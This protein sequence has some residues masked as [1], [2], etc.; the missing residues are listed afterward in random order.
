MEVAG[1]TDII[2][3]WKD[4]PAIIDIKSSTKLKKKDQIEHYFMQASSYAAMV[5]ERTG[6]KINKIVLVFSVDDSSHGLTYEAKASDWIEK[7]CKLRVQYR[8]ENGV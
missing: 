7:F 6:V 3:L 1:R 8:T 5:F 4:D 2:A